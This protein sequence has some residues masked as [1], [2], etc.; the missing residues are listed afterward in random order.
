MSDDPHPLSNMP[1]PFSNVV[2]MPPSEAERAAQFKARAAKL[3]VELC[4]LMDEAQ[5]ENMAIRWVNIGLNPWG[6]HEVVD[7]HIIKRL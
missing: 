3:I 5:R 6:R 4:L 7:L 1:D 2:P